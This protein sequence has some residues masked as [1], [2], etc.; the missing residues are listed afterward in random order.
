MNEDPRYERSPAFP[1]IS[2][3][4]SKIRTALAPG[5]NFVQEATVELAK[6]RDPE[7]WLKLQRDTYIAARLEYRR[8][9]SASPPLYWQAADADSRALLPYFNRLLSW[10]PELHTAR[11]ASTNALFEGRAWFKIVS[12]YRYERIPPDT[13][14]RKWWYPAALVHIPADGIRREIVNKEVWVD[15][16]KTQTRDY[17]WIVYDPVNAVW[18][19]VPQEQ[20]PWYI[21]FNYRDDAYTLGYGRGLAEQLYFYAKHKSLII[22][23]LLQGA[24]RF[25]VP[26]IVAQM[27]I[28][29]HLGQDAG[30]GMVSP[31]TKASYYLDLLGK[32]RSA[33]VLVM[34]SR[35]KL[36]TIDFSGPGAQALVV[37]LDYFDKALSELIVGFEM[38]DGAGTGEAQMARERMSHIVRMDRAVQLEGWK[39]L[40]DAFWW[41]N[42]ENFAAILHPRVNAPLTMLTPPTLNMREEPDD[43]D[44]NIRRLAAAQQIGA[45]SGGL[46][47]LR[48]EVYDAL[49][50]TQ[51]DDDDAA[52]IELGMPPAMGGMEMQPPAPPPLGDG[53]DSGQQGSGE[54]YMT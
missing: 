33:G 54:G 49:R 16:V 48:D 39:Q 53:T 32:M 12:G 4:L 26:W 8:G 7:V 38:S 43:V 20:L 34:D 29:S 22:E 35:D 36:S 30:V 51:P 42:Y 1:P 2:P 46:R 18:L 24:D 52:V 3:I 50:F 21:R 11:Y 27:D 25:S 31:E 14:P 45:Q 37:L 28:S 40:R 47:L 13:Q 41:F 15:G 6:S 5:R 10:I 9:L 23:H 44:V 19:R 17:R